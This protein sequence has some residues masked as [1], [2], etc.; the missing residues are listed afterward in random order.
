MLLP[1]NISCGFEVDNNN[2]G[3]LQGTIMASGRTCGVTN[4]LL[5]FGLRRCA[6]PR[7]C[8]HDGSA[9]VEVLVKDASKEGNCSGRPKLC[10]W[11]MHSFHS[12]NV[13]KNWSCS[14]S[15][16]LPSPLTHHEPNP[17]H[18]LR[19]SYHSSSI[20]QTT[21]IT[22]IMRFSVIATSLIAAG[23]VNAQVDSILSSIGGEVSS[24]IGDVTS[25]AG[26]ITSEAGSAI[27]SA[28]SGASS[29]ISEIE[30]SA[31]SALSSA[32]TLTESGAV[33][34]ARSS[35]AN[36]ASS[37]VQ[38]AASS[39]AGATSS[40]GASV[41]TALPALGAAAGGIWALAGLL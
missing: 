34:S 9:G 35:I 29:A 7:R 10:L 12:R 16:F 22:S 5:S 28:I 36:E 4:Q 30:A 14:P 31:S 6:E 21:F 15:Q 25:G 20:T 32:A 41:P 23:V 37:R 11:L 19:F 38:S 13:Y 40:G 39:A 8:K 1:V 27:S 17:V 33:E 26:S 2:A 24:A 18:L 3:D